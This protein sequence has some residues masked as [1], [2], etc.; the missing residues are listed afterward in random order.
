MRNNFARSFKR[1]GMR[2]LLNF[3]EIGKN[4]VLLLLCQYLELKCRLPETM[5]KFYKV[6]NTLLN[7]F[8]FFYQ[9]TFHMLTNHTKY[10][11]VFSCASPINFNLCNLLDSNV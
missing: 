6:F 11:K 3:A 9:Q 8:L 7:I 1:L 5:S 4:V 2:L 10:V